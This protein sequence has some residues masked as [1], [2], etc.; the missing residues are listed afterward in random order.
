[1]SATDYAA[2]LESVKTNQFQRTG[3]SY[4]TA[5][6]FQKTKRQKLLGEYASQ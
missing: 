2:I 4:Q 5:S 1:M 6:N 3:R